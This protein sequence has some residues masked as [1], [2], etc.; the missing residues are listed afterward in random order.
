M[1]ERSEFRVG[2]LR[3]AARLARR[4]VRRRPGRTALV[5]LLVALPVAFMVLLLVLFRTWDVNQDEAWQREYG[6]ADALLVADGGFDPS[7]LPAG[8]RT[9]PVS[10]TQLRVRT[11]EGVRT[12]V[13]VYGF[14][15]ADPMLDGL[16]D[17]IGGRLPAAG[18]EIALDPDLADGLDVHV[19][20]RLVLDRPAALEL[21][22]VGLVE[23][24]PTSRRRSR[25]PP[26]AA[27]CSTPILGGRR[28][29][30]PTSICPAPPLARTCAADRGSWCEGTSSRTPRAC[31]PSWC[32][33]R[34]SSAPSC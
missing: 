13:L 4:E 24:P 25:S 32:R 20:D 29:P 7:G 28:P 9:A 8:A 31:R 10:D 18:D 1:S 34:T 15:A 21:A 3:L 27:R 30:P 14:A 33:R 16:M 17:L 12:D 11:G 5:A 26:P 6:D 2:E 22:V 19:G 23:K